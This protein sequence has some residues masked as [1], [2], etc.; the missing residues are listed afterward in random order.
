MDKYLNLLS[1]FICLDI[2]FVRRLFAVCGCYHYT[3][4]SIPSI[5]FKEVSAALSL[6]GQSRAF[7]P[8]ANLLRTLDSLLSHPALQQARMLAAVW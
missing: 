8:S 3:P 1:G 6:R 5:Y 7:D 4:G 2:S